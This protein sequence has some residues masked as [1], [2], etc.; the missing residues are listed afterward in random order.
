M[1]DNLDSRTLEVWIDSELFMKAAK[2]MATSDK[3]MEMHQKT[4]VSM[5]VVLHFRTAAR[6]AAIKDARVPSRW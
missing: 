5:E 6:S 4:Y 2:S 3:W 1:S